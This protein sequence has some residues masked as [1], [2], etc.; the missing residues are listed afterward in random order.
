LE[1]SAKRQLQ[2]PGMIYRAES[3]IALQTN[4]AAPDQIAPLY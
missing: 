2:Y 3:K 1:W 4:F